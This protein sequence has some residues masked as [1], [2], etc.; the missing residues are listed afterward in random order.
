[1]Y[2]AWNLCKK[3][4]D[5]DKELFSVMIILFSLDIQP[6]DPN[7]LC[8][9]LFSFLITPFV[10]GHYFEVRTVPEYLNLKK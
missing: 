7:I 10:R 8:H 4:R 6:E 5:M 9:L 1:M 2:Q 3:Y